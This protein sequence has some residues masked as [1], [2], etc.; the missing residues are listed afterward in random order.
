MAPTVIPM[1]NWT[2]S[3]F[4]ADTHLPFTP[5]SP[6]MKT[7]NAT[8]LY[9]GI[10]LIEGTNISVGRGT[11]TPF[12]NIG[13]PYIDAAELAGYLTARKIPGIAFAPT[14]LT[15]AET[16]EKYPS[17]GQTIPGIHFT[18]TDRTALDTPELGIELLA[19]LRHL[20]PT[21]F[22]LDKAAYLLANPETLAALKSGDDPRTIAA[23]WQPAL[24]K[25]RNDT[26]PYLLYR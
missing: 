26:T 11:E 14:T 1:Q 5:P 16:P 23:T 8:I 2:R 24:Q 9:P 18:V 6:N 13:A 21:H 25:F 22:Q 7:L 3:E 17:H 19:A 20:Y 10:G 12:E 4:F 15:I